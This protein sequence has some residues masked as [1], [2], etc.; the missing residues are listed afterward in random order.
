MQGLQFGQGGGQY[1]GGFH[2]PRAKTE[3]TKKSTRT[4]I[5]L[6]IPIFFIAHSSLL[7]SVGCFDRVSKGENGTDS[8]SIHPLPLLF[9]TSYNITSF[10]SSPARG[11]KDLISSQRGNEVSFLALPRPSYQP[12]WVRSERG[13]K[14][15]R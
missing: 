9:G 8:R 13:V 10:P 7:S 6:N 11:K 2:M 14:A 5:K 1:L 3:V 4:Q 12:L 15:N